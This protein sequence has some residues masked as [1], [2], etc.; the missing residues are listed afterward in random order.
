MSESPPGSS[1]VWASKRTSLRL[2]QTVYVR[3]D[4][5]KAIVVGKG[6]RAIKAVR[7]AA[8]AELSESLGRPVHLFLFVK[9]RE[10]WLEDPARYRHWGLDFEA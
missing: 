3:R 8:Q 9:V 2:E 6:G 5:Q 10:N 1:P 4:S 7:E